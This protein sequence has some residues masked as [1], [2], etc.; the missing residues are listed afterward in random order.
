MTVHLHASSFRS[1]ARGLC[2]VLMYVSPDTVAA[3]TSKDT[4]A[5][6]LQCCLK[7][8]EGG[9]PVPSGT[10]S[11]KCPMFYVSGQ[12]MG[13][14]DVEWRP[15]FLSFVYVRSGSMVLGEQRSLGMLGLYSLGIINSFVVCN[16]YNRFMKP[17]DIDCTF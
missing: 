14:M 5:L 4:A 2:R 9:I 8:S 11:Q 15:L 13:G 17:W 10:S 7:E 16:F 1:R 12:G 3:V 6:S